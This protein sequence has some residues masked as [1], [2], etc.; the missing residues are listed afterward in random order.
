MNSAA[1]QLATLVELDARHDDLLQRLEDLDNRVSAVLAQFQPPKTDRVSNC[2]IS[3]DD[4]DGPT[5]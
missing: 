3:G 5:C 4:P 1:I 2:P